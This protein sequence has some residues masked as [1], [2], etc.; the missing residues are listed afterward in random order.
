MQLIG[1]EEGTVLL[2]GFDNEEVDMLLDML[3]C[4]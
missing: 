1:V 2:P 3:C 4:D